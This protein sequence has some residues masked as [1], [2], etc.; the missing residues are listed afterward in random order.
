MAEVQETAESSA[1]NIGPIQ[2]L[3]GIG[4]T[5]VVCM[6]AVVGFYSVSDHEFPERLSFGLGSDPATARIIDEG[7]TDTVPSDSD[8]NLPDDAATAAD[9]DAEQS[10]RDDDQATTST[11]TTVPS[12]TSSSSTSTS[13][14]TTIKP[15]TTTTEA[16]AAPV[17]P[18]VEILSPLAGSEQLEPNVTI[19][20]KAAP[21]T[22]VFAG[23]YEAEMDS[24]GNWSVDLILS[25]GENSGIIKA[26]N[27][28]DEVVASAPISVTLIVEFTAD[29]K[30]GTSSAAE[31]WDNF[32]GTTEP[33]T[34]VEILSA[35]GSATVVAQDD[36]RWFKKVYFTG[37]PANEGFIVTI[38][39][40]NGSAELEFVY[41]PPS[42]P[43]SVDFSAAQE[44]GVNT[45]GWAYEYFAGT[46]NPGSTVTIS[47]D[48]GSVS[49]VADQWGSFRKK[50]I[51]E[52]LPPNKT[53]E[54]LVQAE[55]GDAVF[56]FTWEPPAE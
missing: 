18:F 7:A 15:T 10:T 26:Y 42:T 19:T 23:P 25:P 22:R 4:V 14:S 30:N 38:K 11:S 36:G 16:A 49:T 44:L 46:T 2:V 20:G 56:G 13:T 21:G 28:L 34:E 17:E 31:P 53:I 43:E 45:D 35:Y 6:I 37:A 52:N 39:A 54:V 27:E 1:R 9:Q 8:E 3:I 12:T 32:F 51:F 41:S 5:Y 50:L 55:N 33:G 48:Y 40:V 47:S 29:Q 24:N